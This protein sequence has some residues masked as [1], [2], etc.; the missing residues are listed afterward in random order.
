MIDIRIAELYESDV[1][2]VGS[3]ITISSKVNALQIK[4]QAV[5]DHLSRIT[6]KNF[7]KDLPES[8]GYRIIKTMN[9]KM[10]RP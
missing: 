7:K 8:M 5:S 1:D 2:G 3:Y 4:R 10:Y 6:N 9:N